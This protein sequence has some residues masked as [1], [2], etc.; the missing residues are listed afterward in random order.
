MNDKNYRHTVEVWR[1]TIT[2]DENSV[3]RDTV[4]KVN[5]FLGNLQSLSGDMVIIGD[6]QMILAN[7]RLF[8]PAGIEIQ[9]KDIIRVQLKEYTIHS[10]DDLMVT[11]TE[12]LLRSKI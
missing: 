2:V 4:T 9:Q 5:E 1:K 8:M 12:V 7:Y 6:S 10:I 11:H 3:K